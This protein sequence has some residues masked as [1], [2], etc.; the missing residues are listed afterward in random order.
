ML[1]NFGEHLHRRYVVSFANFS[2]ELLYAAFLRSYTQKQAS[3]W[4]TPSCILLEEHG[5][6]KTHLCT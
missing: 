1:K 3:N 5:G 2:T 6:S 4:M